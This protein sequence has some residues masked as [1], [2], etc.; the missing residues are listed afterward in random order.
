MF[1]P[2][3]PKSE[4]NIKRIDNPGRAGRGGTH[5]FQVCIKRHG[6]E[7]TKHFSDKKFGGETAA[8]EAARAYR[9]RALATLPSIKSTK[10]MFPTTHV[11]NTSNKTGHVGLHFRERRLA[12][13]RTTKYVVAV[14][15]PEPMKQIKKEFRIGDR[16]VEDVFRDALLWRK[17]IIEERTVRANSD[18]EAWD[19]ALAE[20]LARG[21]KNLR[22]DRRLKVFLCHSKDDKDHVRKLY[23]RLLALGCSPWLDDEL[24]LPGQNWDAEIRKAIKS[25]HVF[26]ACLSK[27][28]VTKRGYVQKEIRFALDA[29]EEIPEGDI[30]IIPIKLEPCDAPESL[31]K[32]HWLEAYRDGYGRLISSLAQQTERLGLESLRIGA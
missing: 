14:A 12:D 6:I 17:M 7:Y 9:D 24:L 4:K 23:L 31:V 27:G 22:N 5:G 28:S 11:R 2:R 3:N 16:A 30:F 20:L 26:I 10:G 13:G 32:W 21:Q 29:A 1:P 15:A 8:L 18:R 25:A 19:E